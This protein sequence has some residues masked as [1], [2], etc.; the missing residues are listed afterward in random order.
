MLVRSLTVAAAAAFAL[1]SAGSSALAQQKSADKSK[2]KAVAQ[3]PKERHKCQ[4]GP[5][6]KQTRL[7]METVKDKPVYLAYWSSNG[8]FH[9]SFETWPGDGRARWVESKAGTVINLISGTMLIE[10]SGD[11]YFVHARD[12]DRMPY[13]GTFGLITGTLTVPLKKG[14]CDW[15][16]MPSEAPQQNEAPGGTPE[17]PDKPASASSAA[18]RPAADPG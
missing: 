17:T 2:G 7:V 4:V 8:P 6:E 5:Y 18:A 15:K 12:V 11:K 16:E 1:G 3:G 13:C 9:C 10:R 14:P